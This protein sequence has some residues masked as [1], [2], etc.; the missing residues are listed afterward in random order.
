MQ[1]LQGEEMVIKMAKTMNERER[2][3]W[4]RDDG[5]MEDSKLE[6]QRGVKNDRKWCAT[7]HKINCTICAAAS[8]RSHMPRAW[9]PN[10]S[11]SL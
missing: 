11:L 5:K 9:S 4:R 6:K 10:S 1:R 8:A 7:T 2:E 3:R